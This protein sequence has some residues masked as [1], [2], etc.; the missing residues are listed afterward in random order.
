MASGASGMG[1]V[2]ATLTA[3]DRLATD[4]PHFFDNELDHYLTRV[5]REA[6]MVNVKFINGAEVDQMGLRFI[7]C[8]EVYRFGLSFR[9]MMKFI[10][11]VAAE[12]VGCRR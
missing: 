4:G 7:D 12:A 11:G 10:D 5:R 9:M 3:G 6:D 8:D 1:R 2:Q